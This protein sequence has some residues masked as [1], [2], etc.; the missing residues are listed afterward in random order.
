MAE[1]LPSSGLLSSLHRKSKTRHE[2]EASKVF[3]REGLSCP[4]HVA[5][6]DMGNG[7]HHPMLRVTDFLKTLSLH[8]KLCVLWGGPKQS[9]SSILPEYWKRYKQQ[10]ESHPVFMDHHDHLDRVLP[11][12][13]HADEGE[14]LKKTGIMVVNF[15]SPLGAGTSHCP[16]SDEFM[17]INFLG[18]SVATR[19]L[20]TVCLKK[21]YSKRKKKNRNGGA[22][23]D[24]IFESLAEELRALYYEGVELFV[25]NKSERFYIAFVGLKGDWPIHIRIGKLTRHFSKKGVLRTSHNSG[26]CHLCRAGETHYPPNDYSVDAAWRSTYLTKRPWNEEGP[27]FCIPQ[28]SPA[29]ELMHKFDLFHLLLKGCF[30]EL[31]GSS[32]VACPNRF[33]FYEPMLFK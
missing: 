28:P 32:L 1:F 20:V 17:G 33:P 21:M 7:L 25:G 10:H 31:A 16:W 13:V 8:N 14:T 26:I 9:A 12:Q 15:Q 2:S 4:M 22:Y 11:I 6:L 5:M 30:A 23:L 19:F 29:R 27:F 3:A 18:S 24:K